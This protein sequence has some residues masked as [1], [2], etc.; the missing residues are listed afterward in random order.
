MAELAVDLVTHDLYRDGFPHEL[1]ATL[2]D[3]HPV[4]HHPVAP[5]RRTPDGVTF[6]AVLG[7]PE[8]QEV[9]RSWQQF[10]SLE[11]PSLTKTPPERSGHTIIAS[12]LSRYVTG[13]VLCVDGGTNAA[14]G[15][16]L[17]EAGTGWANAPD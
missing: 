3:E 4:W 14:G 10:S 13:Q 9:S 2:R 1:F 7:H 12:D 16:Y 15:W 8:V 17:N 6:W 5:T 11:G